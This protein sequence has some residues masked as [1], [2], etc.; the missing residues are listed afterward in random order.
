MTY[1]PESGS[2]MK[3]EQFRRVFQV[4]AGAILIGVI[5]AIVTHGDYWA[6]NRLIWIDTG[7]VFV[8]MLIGTGPL[9]L[10]SNPA[11]LGE[12]HG[13]WPP[14]FCWLSPW[15]SS[16]RG[17]SLPSRSGRPSVTYMNK[18]RL[19]N[20]EHPQTDTGAARFL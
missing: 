8:L 3:K 12:V 5:S 13:W 15:R 9:S 6:L 18:L 19:E 20:S 10:D 11:A 4:F 14:L 7:S 2:P 1:S 17:V 16:Q